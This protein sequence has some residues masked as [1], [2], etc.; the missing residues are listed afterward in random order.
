MTDRAL[1]LAMVYAG[2]REPNIRCELFLRALRPRR[3][4]LSDMEMLRDVLWFLIDLAL[5]IAFWVAVG[6]VSYSWL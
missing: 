2:H 4:R 6:Y 5:L 3:S 1:A